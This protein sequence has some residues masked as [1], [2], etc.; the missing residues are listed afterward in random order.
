MTEPKGL[1]P[2]NVILKAVCPCGN[3]IRVKIMDKGEAL[4]VWEVA[5]QNHRKMHIKVVLGNIHVLGKP[6]SLDAAAGIVR[7]VIRD[8]VPI[9]RTHEYEPFSHK[10]KF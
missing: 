4:N 2:K 1:F 6:S 3:R 5:C 8:R 9:V 7:R 10:V